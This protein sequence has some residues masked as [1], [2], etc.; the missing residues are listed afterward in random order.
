LKAKG[1]SV[2]ASG[3]L[4]KHNGLPATLIVSTTLQEL[5]SCTG[6]GVT[7]GGT[8]LPMR[9]VIRQASHAHHYFYIYD[10]HTREPLYLGRT[11]RL[12]SKSQRIVLY[13]TDRGCTR[14]GCTAPAYWCQVHH[15]E[16]DWADG[17]QSNITEE[18]L[19]C[20]PDNR[21]VTEYEETG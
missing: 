14:P 2:L 8:L 11:K 17:G 1:R 18:T 4:G 19:A 16:K 6:H 12:A 3:E 13:A 7:A 10:K 15:A 9:D 20:G 21:M 5:E